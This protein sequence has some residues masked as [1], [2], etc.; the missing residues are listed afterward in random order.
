MDPILLS[1]IYSDYFSLSKDL[2]Y[3]LLTWR[4]QPY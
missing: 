1:L 3:L 4:S 2:G